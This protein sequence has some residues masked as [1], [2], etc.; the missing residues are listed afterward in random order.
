M[1]LLD[2]KYFKN[3]VNKKTKV[4]PFYQQNNSIIRPTKTV[5]MQHEN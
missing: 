4:H 3:A 5:Q 2:M 1:I